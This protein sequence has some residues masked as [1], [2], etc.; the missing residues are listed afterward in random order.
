MAIQTE[1]FDVNG[2]SFTR[3]YSDAGRYVVREGVEYSE[4]C[5]PT[6]FGRT[7]TEGDLMPVVE[8]EPLAQE[9]LDIIMG[10]EE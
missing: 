7:Y 4:A 9:L 5:D 3:T 8:L 10:G 2:R 1:L 6:E